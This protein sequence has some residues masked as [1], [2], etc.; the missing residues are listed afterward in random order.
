MNVEGSM[1]IKISQI[2]K[3]K[4]QMIS[5]MWNLKHKTTHQAHRCRE[6]IGGCQRWG[7]REGRIGEGGQNVQTSSYK[8]NIS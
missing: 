8:T 5:L 2:E 3:N 4:Y 6:Q 1:L 7:V